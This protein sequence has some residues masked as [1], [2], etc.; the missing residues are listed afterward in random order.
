MGMPRFG[1]PPAGPLQIR[2]SM[3]VEKMEHFMGDIVLPDR[4]AI[5]A[6][7]Q[8]ASEAYGFGEVSI[9]VTDRSW[10]H[11]RLDSLPKMV[12]YAPTAVP[13]T[14]AVRTEALD[15]EDDEEEVEDEAD[16]VANEEAATD[17]D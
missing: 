7:L 9:R 15:E 14:E 10:V 6:S 2:V 17:V 12:G 4:Y 5:A 1:A 16:E 3:D 13:H 8:V 11:T